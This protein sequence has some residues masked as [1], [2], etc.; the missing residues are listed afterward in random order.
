[1]AP[2]GLASQ[3]AAMTERFRTHGR[4]ALRMRGQ[5]L[6]R[7][8]RVTAARV[9]PLC[10]AVALYLARGDKRRLRVLSSREV[11][12]LNRPARQRP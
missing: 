9:E 10:W 8:G 12:V 4:A 2:P 1:M 3:N 7:N 11:L 6:Q 5:P